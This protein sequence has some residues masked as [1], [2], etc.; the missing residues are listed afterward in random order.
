MFAWSP[1][2]MCVSWFVQVAG[3]EGRGYLKWHFQDNKGLATVEEQP[4]AW[5]EL[6]WCDAAVRSWEWSEKDLWV[7]FFLF[8]AGRGGT[9]LTLCA[10]GI[11]SK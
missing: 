11:P 7:G 9:K 8:S 10:Q 6:A 1:A 4:V 3:P 2:G 5:E